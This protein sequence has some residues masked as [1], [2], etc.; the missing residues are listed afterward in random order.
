MSRQVNTKDE[1]ALVLH[2]TLTNFDFAT[3]HLQWRTIPETVP[4]MVFW[5]EKDAVCPFAFSA[6]VTS[7]IAHVRNDSLVRGP[8]PPDLFMYDRR[9]G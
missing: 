7:S 6:T 4:V 3:L 9:L 5:G 2:S 1:F 8:H